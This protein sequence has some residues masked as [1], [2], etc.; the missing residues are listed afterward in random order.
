[1]EPVIQVAILLSSAAAIWLVGRKEPWRRWGFIVGFLGQPFWIFD[2]WRHEQWGI[3]ALS[4]W[5]V[6]SYGQGVWNFWVKP[7][8]WMDPKGFAANERRR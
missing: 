1:M 4:I 5:F 7:V 2:S 8:G 6:Y 3:V